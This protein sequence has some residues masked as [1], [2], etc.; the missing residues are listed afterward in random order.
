MCAQHQLSGFTL[1]ELVMVI[2]LIGVLA[3]VVGPRF[4]DNSVFTSNRFEE[5]LVNAARYAHD[6]A[7]SSGCYVQMTLASYSYQVTVDD[8]CLTNPPVNP[9]SFNT[10]LNSPFGSGQLADSAPSGV[11][12]SGTALGK[13]YYA[14]DGTIRA[15]NWSNSPQTSLALAITGSSS[16]TVT[17]YGLSGYVQ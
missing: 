12:L 16:R 2:V 10:G 13:L 9:S 7:E 15:S 6:Y 1:I 4:F 14:P 11:V 8:Q 5:G 3:A 17:F